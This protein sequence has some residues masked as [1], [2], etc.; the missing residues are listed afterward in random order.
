MRIKGGAA[1][2]AEIRWDRDPERVLRALQT[3]EELPHAED[4]PDYLL[5][6]GGQA[7]RPDHLL[8]GW[9][10]VRSHDDL[11]TG[12]LW[13]RRVDAAGEAPDD[14]LCVALE[15]DGGRDALGAGVLQRELETDDRG[16]VGT[17]RS[18]P[19]T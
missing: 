14:G 19:W 2:A 1:D 11:A 12:L 17:P 5:R 7:G 3:G 13:R 16:Q 6:I 18:R 10:A 8:T 4:G 15:F 9:L